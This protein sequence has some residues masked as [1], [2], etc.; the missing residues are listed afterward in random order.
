MP[1]LDYDDSDHGLDHDDLDRTLSGRDAVQK[2]AARQRR[3]DDVM[4]TKG[5]GKGKSS[6]GSAPY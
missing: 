3:D 4:P 5:S 6:K 2:R 1:D